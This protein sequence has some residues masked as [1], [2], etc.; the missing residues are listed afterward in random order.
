MPD[1]LHILIQENLEGAD[2]I[3]PSAN[4]GGEEN[5]LG[6]EDN[7]KPPTKRKKQN[8]RLGDGFTPLPPQQVI[9]D[10]KGKTAIDI[11]NNLKIK[12]K[13]WQKSFYDFPIF[14]EKKFNEKLNYIH[15]NP[16]KAGLVKNLDDYLWSSYQNFYLENNSLIK[17]DYFND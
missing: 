9:H 10:I 8:Q 15:N 5:N 11:R 1:H 14:S 17:I 2:G 12:N 6:S 16:L 13:I 7:I 3:K 4:R